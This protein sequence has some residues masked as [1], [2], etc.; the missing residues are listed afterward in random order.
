MAFMSEKLS[1][2]RQKWTTYEIELYAVVR[3]IKHWEQYLFQQE[4]VLHTDHEA[5][6][7]M[8]TQKNLNRLHARW[9]TYLQQFTF[10]IK[11]KSGHHN[12]VADALSRRASLLV[13]MENIVVGFDCLKEL[14][15]EDVD[16]C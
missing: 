9:V 13:T 3:S 14:Y 16:F 6:K 11:H 1:T 12:K 2:A 10:V 7:Y 8:N 15:H 5:L 4:F